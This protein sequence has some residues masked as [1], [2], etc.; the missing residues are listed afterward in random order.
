MCIARRTHCDVRAASELTLHLRVLCEYVHGSWLA[1]P[2]HFQITCYRYAQKWQVV[3]TI[4]PCHAMPCLH[5]LCTSLLT[6]TDAALRIALLLVVTC[7]QVHRQLLE[8]T[9]R[10]NVPEHMHARVGTDQLT[11]S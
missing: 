4:E 7:L 9:R 5:C 1:E 2:V 8:N 3:I 11:L 10:L 6:P